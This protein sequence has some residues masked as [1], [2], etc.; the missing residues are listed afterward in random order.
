[1]NAPGSKERKTPQ[2]IVRDVMELCADSDTGRN[3]MEEHCV[4]F[5]ELFHLWDR[6]KEAGVP[7]TDADLRSLV[8]LCTLCG[9]CPYPRVPADLMEA[10]SRYIEREGP[11]GD[12]TSHRC[13]THGPP[14]RHFPQAGECTA[15][16]QSRRSPPSQDH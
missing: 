15:V 12:P 2:E 1:M 5:P 3:L 14:V 9:L 11:P 6:K 4:F 16:E 10:K 7:I 13:S 8:E